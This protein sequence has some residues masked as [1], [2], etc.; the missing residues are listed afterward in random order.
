MKS[1]LLAAIAATLFTTG[2]IA[3]EEQPED[4]TGIGTA[5]ESSEEGSTV[6]HEEGLFESTTEAKGQPPAT[7]GQ[8]EDKNET[9]TEAQSSEEGATVPHEEGL[10]ESTPELSE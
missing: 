2:H 9:D 4:T 7:G 1:R 6:P 5:A 8:T 3:G 10:F